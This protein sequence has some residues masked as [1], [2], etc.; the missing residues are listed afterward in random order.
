MPLRDI[1]AVTVGPAE[2]LSTLVY[3]DGDVVTDVVEAYAGVHGYLRRWKLIDGRVIHD[4]HWM[5]GHVRILVP[6]PA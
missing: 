1:T 3:L 4:P 2:A 5:R 6:E